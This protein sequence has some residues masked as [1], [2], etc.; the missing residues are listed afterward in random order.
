VKSGSPAGAASFA[1]DPFGRRASKTV[2]GATTQFQYDGDRVVQEIQPGAG[3]VLTNMGFSRSDLAGDM[4]FLGDLLGSTIALANDAGA[5]A[6]QYSYEPFG[7]SMAS[8][9]ASSNPYQFAF[10]QNDGTGLYYYSARYYSP[11]L[12]RFISEDPSGIGGGPNLYEYAGDQPVTFEDS[13]GLSPSSGSGSC[14]PCDIY[15]RYH[16]AFTQ[17]GLFG[18]RHYFWETLDAGDQPG[19]RQFDSSESERF[20]L[21]ERTDRLGD[22]ESSAFFKHWGSSTE[23]CDSVSAVRAAGAAWP[24]WIEH[25]LPWGPNSNTVASFINTNTF[26]QT[27]AKVGILVDPPQSLAGTL[28]GLSKSCLSTSAIAA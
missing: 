19:N 11:T 28:V 15:L 26:I 1:Y 7:A 21:N 20:F 22:D 2:G 12:G 24:N 4:T 27:D 9:A 8:G 13:S 18:Q 3:N 16:G 6:T 17:Q 25:W 10:H 14:R 5:V 23:L